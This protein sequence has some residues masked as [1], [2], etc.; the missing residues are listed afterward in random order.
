MR[1]AIPVLLLLPSLAS[2]DAATEFCLYGE[3]DLGARYQGM[4][5]APGEFYPTTWCVVTGDES[6]RVLFSGAGHSNPD[7]DGSW[8]VAYLPPDLV[9]I[10]NRESPPDVEFRGAEVG[11]EAL[12]V[13]RIDP[14]RL[15][16]EHGRTPGAL[17]SARVEIADG[18]L[19]RVHASADLP[20]RG[21]VDVTWEWDWPLPD[22]PRLRLV[23]DGETLFRAT[24]RW[25]S[26]SPDESAELWRQTPGAEPVEVAGDRWPAAVDMRLVELADDVYLVR[27]VRTGFQ[28][29]V[30]D[31]SEGLV[32]GDAPAGWLE[33]HQIPP[34]DLVPGLGVSGLSERLVD[35]LR[36]NL[37]GRPIRAVAITHAHDDHAGGARAFAAAGA[38]IY[39]PPVSAAFLEKSLNLEPVPPDRLAERHGR[40]E[41]I[42]ARQADIIGGQSNRVRLMLLG[43]G[44]HVDAM[45]GVWALDRGYFFVS[46]VHVPNSDAESPRPDRARTECWFAAWAVENLRPDVRVVNSHSAPVTPVTRLARYLDSED[47]APRL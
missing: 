25:R 7:L 20:L 19:S 22:E 38:D 11:D 17:D 30:V 13:R 32:V 43:P 12:R 26:L 9:R 18:R 10:V 47:C 4:R 35:F 16:E 1:V 44:P 41:V 14:R 3:L 36:E 27:G 31:T 23:V 37:P 39:A 5:P 6:G 2:A 33:F 8:T 42:G 21:R 28:H 45:L 34:A 15:V 46:D 29:L 24:G 40:V